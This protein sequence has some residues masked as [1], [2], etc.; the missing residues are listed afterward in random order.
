MDTVYIQSSRHVGQIQRCRL[1]PFHESLATQ[2]APLYREETELMERAKQRKELGYTTRL[3][4]TANG[5][6]EFFE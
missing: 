5:S 6:L 1:G 4:S 3:T 2:L